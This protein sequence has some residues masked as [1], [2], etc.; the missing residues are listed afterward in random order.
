MRA[1]LDG[2]GLIH[3]FINHHFFERGFS[4][5]AAVLVPIFGHTYKLIETHAAFR[6]R[7]AIFLASI[8][9]F[10]QLARNTGLDA[11]RLNLVNAFHII[12]HRLT[13][14]FAIIGLLRP[15]NTRQSQAKHRE[16]KK[17]F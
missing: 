2:C 5:D 7:S 16:H 17:C 3:D 9:H 15:R 11:L 1:Q 14:G 6:I 4:I 12:Q 8:S 10:G 13:H